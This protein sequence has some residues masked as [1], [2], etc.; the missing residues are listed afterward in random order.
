MSSR[1]KIDYDGVLRHL[2]T[3][4]G[5]PCV[6]IDFEAAL[7]QSVRGVMPH[8]RLVGCLFHY[9]QALYR[10]IQALGL[11]QS[12]QTDVGTKS[13]MRCYMALPVLP[14]PHIQPVFE[15]LVTMSPPLYNPFTNYI[16]EQ[17]IE[18]NIFTVTDLSIFGME[19]RTNNDVEGYHYRINSKAQRGKWLIRE[20]CHYFVY[21]LP[22][23]FIIIFIAS[24]PFYLLC[25]FLK[26]E[27]DIVEV[28][29]MEVYR[30]E[31]SV[32]RVRAGSKSISDRLFILWQEYRNQQWSGLSLVQAASQLLASF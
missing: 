28:T 4:L 16:R 5:Q 29:V 11:Q 2:L 8:V 9:T 7:W 18:G 25:Q 19:T 20:W 23:I 21:Y 26:S 31:K 13:L 14:A 12:Y 3:L 30:E 27:A 22:L 32:R 6:Q 15:A 24:L 17:W 10:Q 1:R